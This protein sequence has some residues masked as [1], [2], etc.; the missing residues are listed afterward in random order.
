VAVPRGGGKKGGSARLRNLALRAARAPRTLFL[1][2]DCLPDPDVVET[3]AIYGSRGVFIYGF[4][5][6]YPKAKLFPFRDVVDYGS[7]IR[8]SKPEAPRR[9]IVPSGGRW[10]E[11]KSFCFSAP[12]SAIRSSGGFAEGRLGGEV[13]DLARR[14]EIAGCPTLPCLQGG[15]VTC[16]GFERRSSRIPAPQL[17]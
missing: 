7:I 1:D 3:H 14:L 6:I 16:L 4:R 10:R 12:T 5:R 8:H 2:A 17:S 15:T 13:R 11:A 9:H